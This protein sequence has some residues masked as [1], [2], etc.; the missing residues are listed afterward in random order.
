MWAGYDEAPRD[1]EKFDD[2]SQDPRSAYG[3][4]KE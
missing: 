2:G 1:G 4:G 3:M